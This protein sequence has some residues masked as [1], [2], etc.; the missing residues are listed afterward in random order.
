MVLL[1]VPRR[2]PA[3]EHERDERRSDELE[4]ETAED[5]AADV[6]RSEPI[7]V[8]A[9]KALAEHYQH[10]AAR[11]QKALAVHRHLRQHAGE[12]HPT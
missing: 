11:A 8:D 10:A 7:V 5:G 9:V 2:R 6:P 3:E 4:H 1:A 12:E